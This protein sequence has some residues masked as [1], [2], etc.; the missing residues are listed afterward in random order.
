MNIW[1]IWSKPTFTGL[2]LWLIVLMSLLYYHLRPSEEGHLSN[3]NWNF[4]IF[5]YVTVHAPFIGLFLALNLKFYFSFRWDYSFY[6]GNVV[7]NLDGHT[8][9][10]HKK[11]CADWLPWWDFYRLLYFGFIH[12]TLIWS[13]FC[14]WCQLNGCSWFPGE[15]NKETSCWGGIGEGM[16]M[17]HMVLIYA[18][19][20]TITR[21]LY[22]TIVYTL[23][24]DNS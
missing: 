20:T 8:D 13:W 21:L 16:M 5:E 9:I 15:W 12:K 4:K 22:Y 19:W 24:Y 6:R 3:V 17:E 10:I 2:F 11:L 7:E 14:Y 18:F 23:Y 1:S